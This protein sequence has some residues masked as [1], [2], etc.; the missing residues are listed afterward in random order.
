MNLPPYDETYLSICIYLTYTN[1]SHKESN[2]KM[3][4]TMST[5]LWY[6]FL[7][8]WNG[9]IA[10]VLFRLPDRDLMDAI[11]D[12]ED[13]SKTSMHIL[14]KISVRTWRQQWISSTKKYILQ[15]VIE[16]AILRFQMIAE[17]FD[18]IA[19]NISLRLSGKVSIYLFRERILHT[20]YWWFS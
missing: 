17:N 6:G 3:F 20:F 12:S 7:Y 9:N 5:I 2:Q 19:K 18:I 4:S 10:F 13:V 14:Q 11:F 8:M 15:S 1:P 16:Y